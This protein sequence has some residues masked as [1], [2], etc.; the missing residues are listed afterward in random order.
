MEMGLLDGRVIVLTGAGRGIG[1]EV[2][3]LAATEGAKLVV[4]DAGVNVDGDG[5]DNGPAD[6]VVQDVRAAGGEAV[7]NY[8]DV[9]TMEGGES[10][11]QQALDAFGRLDG[12]VNLAAILRDRMVFNMTEE[13]WDE[14]IRVD[15]KGHFTTIKAAAIVFRQQRYGRIINFTSVSGL[16]GNTGQANYGAAKAGVAGLT[17]VVARDL[18]RYGVT[19]NAIAPSAATRLTA[20][21]PTEA[22]TRRAAAGIGAPGG[23][24]MEQLQEER[25]REAAMGLRGPEMVAPMVVYLLLDEAWNINGQTFAVGGGRV[26]VLPQLYPPERQIWKPGLWTLEEL[27]AQVPA[28]LMG[29]VANA[30]PPRADIDVPG[31]G[32]LEAASS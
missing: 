2:A 7:S 32:V 16:Q 13:E 28:Q 27:R 19:C 9:S 17:R 3:L 4:N 20:S 5:H 24:T 26:G 14:V 8:T 10:V 1:R 12:L 6:Q 15:L 21:V 22:L 29:G 18:G 23:A 31:R 25:A 11:V 30:A